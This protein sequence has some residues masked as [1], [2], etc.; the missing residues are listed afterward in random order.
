MWLIIPE[1]ERTPAYLKLFKMLVSSQAFESAVAITW[2]FLLWVL[3]PDSRPAYCSRVWRSLRIP[4]SRRFSHEDRKGGHLV[5]NIASDNV[6][7]QAATQ[8]EI[9]VEYGC[10]ASAETV[11]WVSAFDLTERDNGINASVQELFLHRFPLKESLSWQICWGYCISDDV[12]FPSLRGFYE[13][14]T[15]CPIIAVFSWVRNQVAACVWSRDKLKC[16]WM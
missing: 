6:S 8:T 11:E 5:W 13:R 15:Q 9:I 10:S 12:S 7:S 3:G 4:V 2:G 16:F 1:A 14:F